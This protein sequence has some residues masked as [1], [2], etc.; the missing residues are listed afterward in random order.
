MKKTY[1]HACRKEVVDAPRV[2]PHCAAPNPTFEYNVA[3]PLLIAVSVIIVLSIIADVL[4]NRSPT[5]VVGETYPIAKNGLVCLTLNGLTKAN[6]ATE[7]TADKAEKLGCLPLV[8]DEHSRVKVLDS[9][10]KA[11]KVLVLAPNLRVDNFQGW[12]AAEN[13][14][15]QPEAP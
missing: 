3:K 1:C 2:C 5:Y 11:L 7:V 14:N 13:L 6:Q 12:T 10:E 4:H 9:D 15:P 8:P